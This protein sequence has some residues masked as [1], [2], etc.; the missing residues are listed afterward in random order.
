MEIT[1]KKDSLLEKKPLSPTI[2]NP[3][4]Q[5]FNVLNLETLLR[6]TREYR[7]CGVMEYRNAGVMK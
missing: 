6:W 3:I 1:E 5:V 4:K 2:N 7:R